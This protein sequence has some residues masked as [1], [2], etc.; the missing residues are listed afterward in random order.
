MAGVPE[1]PSSCNENTETREKTAKYIVAV[2]GSAGAIESLPRF[3]KTFPAD[4]SAA[5][6]PVTHLPAR[7]K[8]FLADLITRAGSL[9]AVDAFDGQRIE[10]GI[11]YVA[12]PGKH[13]I[14]SDGHIHLTRGPKEGLHRPSINLTFRSAAAAYGHL[15]IGVVLS[16]MLDD[17]AAGLWDIAVHGGKTIVQDPEEAKFPGMPSNA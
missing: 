3:M 16:G 12:Q 1:W 2:G 15:A 14:I 7:G 4:L 11:G 8:S 9:P 6:F 5:V 17:G 10:A 13:L